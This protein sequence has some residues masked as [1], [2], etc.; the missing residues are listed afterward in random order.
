MLYSNW[1]T[2]RRLSPIR[3]Y[4]LFFGLGF[5]F[6]IEYEN[7]LYHA[8]AAILAQVQCVFVEFHCLFHCYVYIIPLL[9]ISRRK[10]MRFYWTLNQSSD[11]GYYPIGHEGRKGGQ[12]GQ[13]AKAP[14]D[15]GNFSKKGCFLDF[16]WDKINFTTFGHHP[17]KILE[18]CPSATT[19]K[20]ILPTPMPIAIWRTTPNILPISHF[21]RFSVGFSFYCR[22]VLQNSS[23]VKNSAPTCRV[24]PAKTSFEPASSNAVFI[25]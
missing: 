20:K 13:G 12:G 8:F 2:F 15:F 4:P 25:Q 5:C 18:K 24:L 22:V 16:E 7:V 3:Y 9:R 19:L 6:A 21:G 23:H 14:L 10:I 17:W 1:F 11:I